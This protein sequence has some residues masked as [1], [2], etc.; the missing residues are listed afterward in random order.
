MTATIKSLIL[1]INPGSTSTKIAIYNHNKNTFQK[2]IKHNIE[3]LSVFE[4]ISDQY[5]FRKKIILDE[6]QNAGI[7]LNDI[8]IIIGRGGLLRPIKSG[9]YEV[10]DLMIEHLKHCQI[11]QHAS[12]LGALIS[13]GMGEDLPNARILI[14]DPVV[15]DEFD[16]IARIAGHPKFERKSIFHALNQ[17]SIAKTYAKS[18]FQKYEELNLIV[19][20]VGGGITV[21]AHSNGRVIDVNQGLDGDGPFSAERSGTLPIGEVINMCF[22]G[23]YTIDEIRKMITGE[24]GLVAYLGTNSVLEIE[25]KI[26]EGDDHAKF[27]YEAM[28]YQVAKE[29]GAVSTVLKGKVDAIL[30][31]GG[32][33]YDE[34][35]VNWIKERVEFIAPIFIYPGE[36]EMRALAK[37]AFSVLTGEMEVF[38]YKEKC[39]DK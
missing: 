27:I 26:R 31:T 5:E 30:I 6:L 14:A 38:E 18:R 37:N 7:D 22:S 21:G 19:A 4:K 34:R 10:N 17:K 32:V 12:N 29:I 3:E 35:F 24:G 2:N 25:A 33:A 11:G 1:V 28:A 9:V 39:T 20:H 15:V 13:R 8:V 36:D 16:D 23:D